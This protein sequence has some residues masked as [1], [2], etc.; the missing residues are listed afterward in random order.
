MEQ[1][2]HL[3]FKNHTEYLDAY[4]KYQQNNAVTKEYLKKNKTNAIPVEIANTFPYANEV[5]NELRSAIEAW[6]FKIKP[7]QKYLVYVN[8]EKRVVTTWTGQVLGNITQIGREFRS[9]MG[10]KRINIRFKGINTLNYSGTFYKSAGDYAI[11]RTV[12]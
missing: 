2:Q 9:N 1:K 5:T 6:E 11:V 7:P 4:H 12:L 8:L 10:D 3:E